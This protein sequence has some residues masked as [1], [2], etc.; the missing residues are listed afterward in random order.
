MEGWAESVQPYHL[1][2]APWDD[3]ANFFEWPFHLECVRGFDRREEFRKS[4]TDW[5]TT[6]EDTITV[7]DEDGQSHEIR[8]TGLGFTNLVA[9]LPTG[10][11][12]E[13]PRFNEWVFIEHAGPY[14][15]V[16]LKAAEALSRGEDVR[17]S[18]GEGAAVLPEDPGAEISRWSLPQL[19]DF[20]TVRD[21]YQQAMDELEPDYQY[22]GG[23]YGMAGFVLNYSLSI[24]RPIPGEAAEFFGGYL[25][26]YVKK[27]PEDA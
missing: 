25:P 2:L 20:L 24:I 9:Q 23:G 15:F 10:R 21:L 27:R 4:I 19:L 14:H 5:I 16:D 6:V 22:W 8:R 18:D 12:Y 3:E 13:N 17:G 11:V 26:S 7:L 1:I